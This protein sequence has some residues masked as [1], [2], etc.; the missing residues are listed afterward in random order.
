MLK[1]KEPGKHQYTIKTAQR[2][3][4]M[5]VFN[6]HA[7]EG[8]VD[9]KALKAIFERVGYLISP[10]HFEDICTRA[11]EFEEKITFEHFMDLFKVR[12]SPHSLVDI[13]NAFRLLA[14]E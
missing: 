10:E 7:V 6:L 8:R 2:Q 14:G 12:E 4:F 9:R 11:F 5:E 3:A 1:D 13:K